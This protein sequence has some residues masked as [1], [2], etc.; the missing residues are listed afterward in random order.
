MNEQLPILALTAGDAAGI[1]PEIVVKS[2]AVAEVRRICRP[3]VVG[4][5][6]I[7][8]QAADQIH[9]GMQVRRIERIADARFEPDQVDV[10]EASPLSMEQFSPGQMSPDAGRAAVN[11]VRAA[12]EFAMKGEVDFMV[13]GPLNKAAVLRSGLQFA[14][15]AE[16]LADLTGTSDYAMMLAS[17]KLRVVHVSTHVSLREAIERVKEDR[18]LATI[19][20]AVEGCR[21]LGIGAPSV[22]VAG[23]NPHAGEAGVLGR[24][25]IDEILPAINAARADG[26]KV[27]GPFPPD[28]VFLRCSR[29]EFSGVVAMYHDQGHIPSRMLAFKTG[30]NVTLGLPIIRTAGDNSVSFNAAGKGITDPADMVEAIRVGAQMA[31]TLRLHRATECGEPGRR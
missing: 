27:D 14:G 8:R 18:V 9:L 5:P 19:R 15:H 25:E 29:G 24:E 6:D 30:V 7:I 11:A 23:L 31:S 26:L 3:V 12:G 4:W 10:L 16:L 20:L 2:L 21:L 22:A 1:G 17:G 13:T 28:T